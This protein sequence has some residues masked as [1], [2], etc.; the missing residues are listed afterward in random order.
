MK[1]N[2]LVIA[3]SVIAL[4]AGTLVYAQSQPELTIIEDIQNILIEEE[5]KKDGKRDCGK[6]DR[7]NHED[8]F[9][10]EEDEDGDDNLK[11]GA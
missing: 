5:V 9:K 3:T 10:D 1:T 6:H 2:T 8:D 7:D 11:D 4:A